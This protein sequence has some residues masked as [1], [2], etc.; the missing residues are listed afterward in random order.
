M[1]NESSISP[2]ALW[3]ALKR[4]KLILLLPILLLT[5]AVAWYT[6][7]L[8]QRFRAKALVGASRAIPGHTAIV[9][10]PEVAVI[11]AQDQLRAIRETLLDS[12]VVEQVIQEFKLSDPPADGNW[13]PLVEA[14]KARIQIQVEGPEAFYVGFDSPQAEQA[15]RVANRLAGVFL[16]QTSNVRG[17]RVKQ[18]DTFL[19]HEVDQLRRQLTQEEDQVR[20]Y[21]S[22]VAQQLP[23]RLS[24]NLKQLET[25]QQQIH[26]KTDQLTEGQ[27]RIATITEELRNLESRGVLEAEPP[28]KTT[29]ETTLEQLRLKLNELRTKYTP[30]HPEIRRAEKQI[31]DMEAIK[32]PAAPVR[33]QAT[34]VQL[35]YVSLQ[36][37]LKSIEP[38]LNSYRRE[39]D[40][41]MAEMASY[42][43]RVNS[44]PGFETA[45]SQRMRDAAVT[46]TRYETLLAKQQE[47]RLAHKVEQSDSGLTYKI[48]EPATLPTTPFSPQR[49]TILLLGFIASLGLGLAGVVLAER[50]H[51]SFETAE[52]MAKFTNLPVLTSVPTISDRPARKSAKKVREVDQLQ[53]SEKQFTPEQKKH[54]QEHRLSVLTD[55]HSVAAQQYS[56]LAL[57]IQHWMYQSGGKILAVTSATGAEGKSVTA[58]NLSLALAST[59]EGRVLLIDGDLR[60]PQV[61]ERLN[62][63][64]EK[65]F[66]DLLSERTSSAARVTRVGNLDVMTGGSRQNN[67]ISLLASQWTRDALAKLRE[68]YQLIVLDSPPV[69][70]IA[71]SH[72]LAGLSDG[73]VFVVRARVT[74]PE[75]FQRGV[76]SLG[77]ANLIGVVLNDVELA[78][79]PYAYAYQHYENHYLGRG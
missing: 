65:G 34:A 15:M 14:V 2:G 32:A 11:N 28:A 49:R 79:T 45:V 55:P 43:R 58:I 9:P 70:P 22:S 36:A 61:H 16:E 20:V 42:E 66:G 8:P 40:A 10:R 78:A 4:R 13:A 46:R 54:F 7:H 64:A 63:K 50:M 26:A 67:P 77:A 68:E 29:T 6:L 23:E 3:R 21:K 47:T 51:P 71:D 30:E 69:V 56:I 33:H 74:R 19:D 75:V 39:R 76:E 18:E 1:K 59:L 62:L 60:L 38:R 24:A 17:Q 73:V 52:Q 25:L 57:K 48:L 31:Q 72:I 5:P 27:A 44:A 41:L 53:D 37:E 35:R 12:T